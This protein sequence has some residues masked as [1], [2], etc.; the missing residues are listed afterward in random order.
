M[1]P[2]PRAAAVPAPPDD[3]ANLDVKQKQLDAI[4]KQIADTTTQAKNLAV[5]I[6]AMQARIAEIKKAT[7]SF[8][9]AA[10]AQQNEL[11]SDRKVIE[12]KSAMASAAITKEQAT[13]VAQVVA[14]VD[15]D[16]STK[17]DQVTK[18]Q[19]AADNAAKE[20]STAAAEAKT[21]REAY[22]AL[23]QAPKDADTKLKAIK[24]L[25]TKASVS[26][27]QGDI[28][29]M[30]YLVVN[31]AA[32]ALKDIAIMSPG[33]YAAK[34]KAAQTDDQLAQSDLPAKQAAS[35][36]AS[37]DLVSAQADLNA[38]ESGRQNNILAELKKVTAPAAPPVAPVPAPA[39]VGPQAPAA[40]QQPGQAAPN[41]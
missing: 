8:S 15:K 40:E 6:K 24:D 5:E 22:A 36:A 20:L 17:S 19:Q 28:V 32:T 10:T 12:Q 30:Y 27:G 14:A 2:V 34:L 1:P 39:G 38:A 13:A 4:N 35:D 11:D 16:I 37:K 18:R 29:T 26:E 21:K 41:P 9:A 7:D 33:E 25:I 3:A 23:Q 31:E